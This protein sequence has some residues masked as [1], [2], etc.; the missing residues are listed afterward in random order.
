MRLKGG[1]GHVSSTFR[2]SA[3]TGSKSDNS[4]CIGG[5]IGVDTDE[6]PPDLERSRGSFDAQDTDATDVQ[7]WAK[8]GT[9]NSVDLVGFSRINQRPLSNYL[10]PRTEEEVEAAYILA[11]SELSAGS[12]SPSHPLTLSPT[13]THSHTLSHSHP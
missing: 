8:R 1:K 4:I 3:G 6:Y 10:T 7:S 5:T 11:Q 12:I 9:M 2:V 13:L